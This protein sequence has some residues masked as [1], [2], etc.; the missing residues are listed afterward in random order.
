MGIDKFRNIIL[1][2]RE[3]HNL[4]S[5]NYV[6]GGPRIHFD[7]SGYDIL[8]WDPHKIEE[9]KAELSKR[10]RR[11]QAII[12]PTAE[13][14]SPWDDEWIGQE[15]ANALQGLWNL[16]F[17][18]YMEIRFALDHPKPS[19]SQKTLLEAGEKAEIKTF[20]WPIGVT[21]D[22]QDC[23]P[24]PRSGGIF[25]EVPLDTYDYWA[26]QRNGDFY[27]LQSLFEDMKQQP[28]TSIYFNT[29]IVRVTE[30]LLYCARLYLN[31]GIDRSTLVSFGA[32]HGGLAGR[33]LS[34]SGNRG[35]Y[36]ME[37]APAAEDIVDKE[38]SFRL[39]EIESRLVE[40]V[41][42]LLAPVFLVF[43]FAEFADSV[44]EDIVNK[45]VNGTVS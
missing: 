6:K 39:E 28:R 12:S 5:P 37:R 18:G 21:L 40:I 34:A 27:L 22:R 41:K 25:A 16:G 14:L 10:I 29:R 19:F 20:G 9:F 2:A 3:D 7:L 11:R 42:G 44:Y 1:T 17:K 24:R 13:R 33:I 26:L 36:L 23:R 45:F 32:K 43:D 35:H 30:A 8:F 31:L 15:R 38:T 4:T